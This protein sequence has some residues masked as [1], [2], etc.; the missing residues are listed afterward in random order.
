VK[1][2]TPR[3]VDLIKSELTDKEREN[4]LK[5]L[6]FESKLSSYTQAEIDSGWKAANDAMKK[7]GMMTNWGKQAVDILKVFS[8][9]AYELDNFGKGNK[10]KQDQDQGKQNQGKQD[11]G[12]QNQGKQNQGKQNQGKQK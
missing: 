12:K 2:G 11:Q 6:E 8:S 10:G 4:I 9:A 1:S 3:E 5:R 7:V